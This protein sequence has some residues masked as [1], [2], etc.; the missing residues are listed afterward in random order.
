VQ[1]GLLSRENAFT[2]V[3]YRNSSQELSKDFW[4]MRRF[5]W[6]DL[7]GKLAQ[8]WVFSP[9]FPSVIAPRWRPPSGTQP[10]GPFVRWLR[11]IT[12]CR[13]LKIGPWRH[14]RSGIH[15]YDLTMPIVI[16]PVLT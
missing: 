13:I 16:V 8:H 2:P 3:L 1:A 15:H 5:G 6:R 12:L 4:M 10:V 7:I 9:E 14:V 11:E